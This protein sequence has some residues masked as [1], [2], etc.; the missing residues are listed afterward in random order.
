MDA[1]RVSN[2][3]DRSLMVMARLAPRVSIEQAQRR[4]NAEARQ[5]GEAVPEANFLAKDI[6]RLKRNNSLHPAFTAR[7]VS[8]PQ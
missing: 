3:A 8:G 6:L 2:R 7:I 1:A 4:L 5:I